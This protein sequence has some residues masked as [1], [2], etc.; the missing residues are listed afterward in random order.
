[1]IS[2]AFLSFFLLGFIIYSH[3]GKIYMTTEIWNIMSK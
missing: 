1:M 3:V 2:D